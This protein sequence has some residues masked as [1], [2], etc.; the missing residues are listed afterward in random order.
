MYKKLF[1][2]VDSW[3]LRIDWIWV[4]KNDIFGTLFEL[5]DS[6]EFTYLL[7]L[8]SL[9]YFAKMVVRIACMQDQ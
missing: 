2:I 7:D 1:D 6:F 5:F 4:D 3:R 9:F 8:V